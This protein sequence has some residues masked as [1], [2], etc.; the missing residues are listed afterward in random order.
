MVT[1]QKTT[2][3]FY[4]FFFTFGSRLKNLAFFF[5]SLVRTQLPIFSQFLT[6][7][8]LQVYQTIELLNKTLQVT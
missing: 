5:S 6:F 3:N 4:T 8:Y 2:I 1:G 7:F